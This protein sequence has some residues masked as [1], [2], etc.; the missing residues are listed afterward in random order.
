MIS[1]ARGLDKRRRITVGLASVKL[2]NALTFAFLSLATIAI[3]GLSISTGSTEVDFWQSLR[4]LAGGEATELER[5]AVYEVRLPRILL[6]FMT[7]WV[8]AMAGAMLQSM[9]QN[10]L[11]DPGL[12]GLSQ[13]ALTVLMILIVFFPLVPREIYPFA[14]MLGGLAVGLFLLLLTGRNNTGGIAILLMGIAVE[15]TLGSVTAMLLLYTPPEVSWSLAIWLSGS[16]FASSW[17]TVGQFT[18]WYGFAILVIMALGRSTKVMD[19][20]DQ[21]AMSLGEGVTY[22]KPVV[23]VI[24]VLITAAAV[25]QVG[26]MTFLGILAPHLARFLSP[27]NGKSRLFL[28]G[29]MGGLLVILADLVTR[30]AITDRFMP[31]GLTIIIVG[32]PLFIISLRLASLRQRR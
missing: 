4:I 30:S 26:P 23:L 16:L 17:D 7:G 5:Y 8:V 22:S 13:G 12:L 1:I 27:A 28:A 31:I 21:M 2:H 10:P 24:C 14:A 19:L 3:A 18:F 11:A 29:M 25:T 20:G 6:G 9:A 15:T 32:A